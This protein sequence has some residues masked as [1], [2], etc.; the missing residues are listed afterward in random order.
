MKYLLRVLLTADDHLAQDEGGAD[1]GGEAASE[2]VE[3]PIYHPAQVEYGGTS[4]AGMRVLVAYPQKLCM[5]SCPVLINCLLHTAYGE[6]YAASGFGSYMAYPVSVKKID[7]EAS[8]SDDALIL[9]RYSDFL[10]LR[11]TISKEYYAR[12]IPPMPPKHALGGNMPEEKFL[13]I[14]RAALEKFLERLMSHPVLS[15]SK[16]LDTFLHSK[17]HE[18][19]NRKKDVERLMAGR[20]VDAMVATKSLLKKKTEKNA[21]LTAQVAKCV[22]P[23]VRLPTAL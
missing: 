22:G 3:A 18:L 10:W 17:N 13:Q 5:Y 20:K 8:S 12:L 7:E 11:E 23:P 15:R 16:A 1:E 6:P 14:R 19:A 4:F 2:G 9:R 21:T